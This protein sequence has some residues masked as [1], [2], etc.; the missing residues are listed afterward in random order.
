MN[1]SKW[2]QGTTWYKM[3]EFSNINFSIF[4]WRHVLS[5]TCQK[6]STCSTP[7][8]LSNIVLFNN[9]ELYSFKYSLGLTVLFIYFLFFFQFWNWNFCFFQH[10]IQTNFHFFLKVS[11]MHILFR[12]K[13]K[14]NMEKR[15]RSLRKERSEDFKQEQKKKYTV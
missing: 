10:Q 14:R 6:D 3:F 13:M 12:Q 7:L 15:V 9:S 2:L 1:G 11:I 5:L 4:M 8:P